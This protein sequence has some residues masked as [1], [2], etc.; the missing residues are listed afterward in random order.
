M[1]GPRGCLDSS[2]CCQ[3]CD[4]SSHGNIDSLH[5]LDN[6]ISSCEDYDSLCYRDSGILSDESNNYLLIGKQWY[7]KL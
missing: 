5:Y 7:A 3:D 2:L 4:I 6:D 1:A